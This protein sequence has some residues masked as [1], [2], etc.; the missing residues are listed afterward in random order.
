[1][2][3]DTTLMIMSDHGFASWRRSFNLNTW[4]KEQGYLVLKNPN[5][6]EDPGFFANVDWSQTRAYGLGLNGLYVNLSGREKTGIVSPQAR[7]DLVKEISAKLLATRD[8]KTGEPA[9]TEV[10]SREAYQDRG[11]LAIGPDIIVGYARGMRCSNESALGTITREVFTDN[12][13]EW[14][15]DHAMDHR[16]V[17]GIFLASRSL[18]RPPRRLTE[19]AD[20]ILA[21]FGI[22]NRMTSR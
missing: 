3:P 20:A 2:G 15:G 13:E 10:H 22:E 8:P 5:L 17:P 6:E 16:T 11:E 1:M 14:S 19:V 4:L 18:S 7:E 21:E 12:T 9:V